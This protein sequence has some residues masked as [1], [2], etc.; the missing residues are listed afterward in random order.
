M[1]TQTDEKTLQNMEALRTLRASP[2]QNGEVL[3]LIALREAQAREE[4]GTVCRPIFT[5]RACHNTDDCN[6]FRGLDWVYMPDGQ[7]KC[8]VVKHHYHCSHCGGLTQAG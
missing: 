8:G 7:C 2:V 5:R 1:Q 6:L 3:A 4:A